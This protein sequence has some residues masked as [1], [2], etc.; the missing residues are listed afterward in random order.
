[1]SPALAGGFLTVG[2]P[3]KS[4]SLHLLYLFGSKGSKVVAEGWERDISPVPCP[5]PPS[6]IKKV[7]NQE[8]T[9][10]ASGGDHVGFDSSKDG[11]KNNAQPAI[12]QA[13]E[14]SPLS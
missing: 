1:M 14:L 4:S 11:L 12:S 7:Q 9:S 3:G 6:P 10:Q 5:H 13:N 8:E 2:P